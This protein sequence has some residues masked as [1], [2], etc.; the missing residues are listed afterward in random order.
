MAPTRID[1]ALLAARVCMA[2]LFL[3]SGI[4][5]ALDL[6]GAAGFAASR[7]VPFAFQLMPLAVF[8]ELGC[9]LMLVTGWGARSAAVIL[10]LWMLVLFSR[11]GCSPIDLVFRP[12]L[13]PI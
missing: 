11:A 4:E 13:S 10:A 8:L 6:H 12:R 2:S 7:G 1:Y 3:W 9:G 5:K